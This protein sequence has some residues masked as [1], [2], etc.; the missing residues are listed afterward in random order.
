MRRRDGRWESYEEVCHI[1]ESVGSCSLQSLHV[2]IDLLRPPTVGP[3]DGEELNWSRL[4]AAL[5]AMRQPSLGRF[6]IGLIETSSD[7]EVI[8]DWPT[9]IRQRLQGL[10]EQVSLHI[11][12]RDIFGGVHSLA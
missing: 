2:D 3:W 7:L 6:T 10:P 8:A 9:T 11:E 4:V 5:S 12:R 1:L